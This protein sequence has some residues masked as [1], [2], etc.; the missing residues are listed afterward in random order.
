MRETREMNEDGSNEDIDEFKAVLVRLCS[1]NV[2][3]HYICKLAA[4][5]QES[6]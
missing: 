4:R 2:P 1:M 3:G 5:A 6:M